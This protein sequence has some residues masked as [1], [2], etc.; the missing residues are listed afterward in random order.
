MS[1]GMPLKVFDGHALA[2]LGWRAPTPFPEALAAT[3]EWFAKTE[4]SRETADAR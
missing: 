2:E 3:Y 1:D 4:G